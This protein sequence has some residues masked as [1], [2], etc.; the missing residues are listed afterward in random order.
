M[1]DADAD[2]AAE[3]L[4]DG[5]FE[6][7]QVQ[8]WEQAHEQQLL[9]AETPVQEHDQQVVRNRGTLAAAAQLR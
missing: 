3:G 9:Q 6:Q 7:Q 1:S 4:D 2:A 8:D 5:P